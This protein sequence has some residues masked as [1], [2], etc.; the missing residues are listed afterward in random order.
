MEAVF[1]KTEKTNPYVNLAE[2]AY[3]LDYVTEHRCIV[4]FLWQNEP[5]VVIGRHQNAYT[6]CN[7]EYAS[8]KG[9]HIARR[10][11]GGG[12][13][14]HDLGNLNYSI[15]TPNEIYDIERSTKMIVTALD[16]LGITAIADGRNDI[17]LRSGEKVSGNAYYSNNGVGLHH[18]TILYNVDFEI[19]KKVL[20]VQAEKISRHGIDSVVARVANLKQVYPAIELKS[21]KSVLYSELLR[22]YGCSSYSNIVVDKDK[23]Q[24]YVEKFSSKE[25]ILDYIKDYK[26]KQSNQFEWGNVLISFEMNGESP[27]KVSITSDALEA[28][29]IEAFSD[30]INKILRSSSAG[31]VIEIEKFFNTCSSQITKDLRD[32]IYMMKVFG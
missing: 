20:C 30:T 3:L 12:A 22:E 4:F 18:G 32:L 5:T 1:I 17:C 9:I 16:G 31:K 15:I 2:E 13:V 11:T 8:L 28:T 7:L 24:K 21:I 27:T 25:W 26:I 14:Y 6:E 19:L 23:M 10:E 29:E